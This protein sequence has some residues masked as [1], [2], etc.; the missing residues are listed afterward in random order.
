MSERFQSWL[1]RSNGF[2]MM[3]FIVNERLAK[4]SGLIGKMARAIEMGERQY[5]QHTFGR[6]FRVV[7]YYW[8]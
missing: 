7:N 3:Q 5:S 1:L 8:V 4:R 2:K 6:A